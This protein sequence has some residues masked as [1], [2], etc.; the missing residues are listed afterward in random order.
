MYVEELIDSHDWNLYMK[1]NER[2]LPPLNIKIRA[3]NFSLRALNEGFGIK[4]M[5]FPYL[6]M[7][8]GFLAVVYCIAFD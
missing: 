6:P 7:C 5:S 2:E 4:S 1:Q 8:G 3:A